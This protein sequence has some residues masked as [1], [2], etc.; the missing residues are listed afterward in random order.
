[1]N[2]VDYIGLGGMTLISVGAALIYIPAGVII[3]GAFLL[4]LAFMLRKSAD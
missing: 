3:A 2:K 1:M 4:S